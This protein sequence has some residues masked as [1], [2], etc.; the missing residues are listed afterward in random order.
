MTENV[1]SENMLTFNIVFCIYT[2]NGC[3]DNDKDKLSFLSLQ[4]VS[5]KHSIAPGVRMEATS[6]VVLSLSSFEAS[7]KASEWS[8]MKLYFF[9]K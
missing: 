1:Q 9:F 2:I 5:D 7:E 4:N 3:K 8:S 6:T